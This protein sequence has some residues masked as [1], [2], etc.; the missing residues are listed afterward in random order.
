MANYPPFVLQAF[1]T[2]GYTRIRI[3]MKESFPKAPSPGSDQEAGELYNKEALDKLTPSELV[4]FADAR[5]LDVTINIDPINA[6]IAV[7]L[8]HAIKGSR[9]TY[10]APRT[11]SSV[12]GMEDPC[13]KKF[14]GINDDQPIQ[15]QERF[16]KFYYALPLVK[17]FN[18]RMK[19]LVESGFPDRVKEHSSAERRRVYECSVLLGKAIR[20]WVETRSAL[21]KITYRKVLSS[22]VLEADSLINDCSDRLNPQSH[23]DTHTPI[24]RILEN[25]LTETKEFKLLSAE[26]KARIEWFTEIFRELEG[27][28]RFLDSYCYYSVPSLKDYFFEDRYRYTNSIKYYISPILA[29]LRGQNPAPY[30][31]ADCENISPEDFLSSRIKLKHIDPIREHLQSLLGQEIPPPKPSTTTPYR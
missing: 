14:R 3:S 29:A 20:A 18:A 22:L 19:A 4:K 8:P 25:L 9:S 7:H 28:A 30:F 6:S 31:H 1:K 15:P 21:V 27:C 10:P 12:I 17:D 26:E 2:G 24:H 5:G 16:G 23:T 11:Y 13:W